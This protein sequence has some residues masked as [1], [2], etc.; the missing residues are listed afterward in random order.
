MPIRLEEKSQR[1]SPRISLPAK[2]NVK[3]RL[4]GVLDWSMQG[5]KAAIPKGM[6]PE[7]W[8]GRVTFILPLQEMEISFDAVARVRRQGEESVG[9]SFDSLPDRSKAL[10]STYIKA[11]IEG[12]LDD[13]D[14]MIARVEASTTPVETDVPLS[15]SERR[16]FKR[17]F[18]GRAL[19][20]LLVGCV[21]FSVFGFILFNNFARAR[22]TRAVVSGGLVDVAPELAGVL[23]SVDVAEGQAVARGQLLFSLDDRDLL[24]RV[25]D[26]RSSISVDKEQLEYFYVLLRE[27]AK[28]MGLYRKAARHEAERL[29]ADLAGLDARLEVARKE[30]E[31][32]DVLKKSGAVS[33]SL[34]DERRETFLNLQAERRA[35]DARLRLAD[36]N[37]LS[38]RD[39]KYLSDG[40]TRGE[41]RELEARANVQ[42]R[43]LEQE[44]LR[45]SQALAALE[46]TRVVS[47]ADGLV[48]AVKRVAGTYLRAGESV[49][50][51]RVADARPWILARF[52]FKE[53]ERLAPGTEARIY[54]PSMDAFY[55][56]RVQALGHQAMGSGDA[57]SQDKEISLNEVPVKVVF[58]A[59]PEGLP[60]GLGAVVSIDTPWLRALKSLL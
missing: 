13:I 14:G 16:Q 26:I 54:I 4:F 52:T 38:A 49:M 45:L 32:A 36:E 22:S 19:I 31:R 3:G 9:F 42:K 5:F 10:L 44:E 56:G 43:V 20:Y 30:F 23:T 35:A 15:L 28:S 39:G 17:S 6:I 53:A 51:V 40:K 18:L 27:E 41:T 2:V 46:K 50:S 48:Y 58:D 12:K 33:Q 60:P 21:I 57:V 8:S 55:N 24:R 29:R 25:E 37:V 47:K 59:L 34:W 11:S 1:K 7:G